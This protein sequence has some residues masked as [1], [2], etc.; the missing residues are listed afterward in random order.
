ME[1]TLKRKIAKQE[2]NNANS[3]N[4]QSSNLQDN[5]LMRFGHTVTLS[6]NI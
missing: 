4:N 2:P 3:N 5:E 1:N 6:K